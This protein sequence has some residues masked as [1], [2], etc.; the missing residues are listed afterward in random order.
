MVLKSKA[1][2]ADSEIQKLPTLYILLAFEDYSQVREREFEERMR[3]AQ[4]ERDREE[5]K[6][7]EG[8]KVPMALISHST[9]LT[10]GRVR[11]QAFLR[12]LVDQDK[13]KPGT[14]WKTVYPLFNNDERYTKILGSPGSGT[15]ELFWDVVDAMDQKPE[16]KIDIAEGRHQVIQRTGEFLDVVKADEDRQVEA[17]ADER[18]SDVFR[19]VSSFLS[20]SVWYVLN[21]PGQLHEKVPKQATG[22]RRG[23]KGSSGISEMI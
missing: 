10:H 16:G 8:F 12:E 23:L 5:R 15:L 19:A 22:E 4:V 13:V 17:L 14:K 1:W 18:L 9:T 3:R 6:T 20:F 21:V 2:K 7:R 11:L